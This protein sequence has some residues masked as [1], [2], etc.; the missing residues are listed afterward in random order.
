MK[1]LPLITLFVAILL[2]AGCVSQKTTSSPEKS[3]DKCGGIVYDK[4]TQ[5]CCGSTLYPTVK[6]E[7]PYGYW[8]S[9]CGEEYINISEG[10]GL[11]CCSNDSNWKVGEVWDQKNNQGC[12]NG[13]IYS[14]T[15]SQHCCNGKIE[16]GGGYWSD[17]GS[18]CYNL[19]KQSCCH[20]EGNKT[21]IHEGKSSCCVGRPN[22]VDGKYCQPDTGFYASPGGC[23]SFGGG[24][25]SCQSIQQDIK[26]QVAHV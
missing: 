6:H 22:L 25:G 18:Q 2:I 10:S 4:S 3:Y 17:C 24:V 16:S 19:E 9:C 14:D 12:C 21:S 5:T 23:N 1:H 7:P 11:M 8:F 20:E 15:S 26:R 13:K